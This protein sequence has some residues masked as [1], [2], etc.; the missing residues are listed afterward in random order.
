ME[1][2]YIFIL[3]AAVYA[4]LLA[5]AVIKTGDKRKVLSSTAEDKSFIQE[6]IE[7]KELEIKRSRTELT[8]QQYMLLLTIAPVFLATIFF[9][10]MPSIPVLSIAGA[11]AG[12]YIPELWLK[13]MK[14]KEEEGYSSKFSKALNQMS[15]SLT[16]KMSFEKSI[17][18]VTQSELIDGNVKTDFKQLLADINVGVPVV[19]AFERYAEFTENEDVRDTATAISIMLE[20]GKGEGEGI[21]KIQKNIEDRMLYRKQRK[22]MMTESKILVYTS[23]FIPLLVFLIIGTTSSETMSYYFS[24]MKMTVLFFGIIVWVLIGSVVIHKLMGNTKDI[25]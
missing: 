5:V 17:E 7:K 22:A 16:S 12:F 19:K 21:K 3:V 18:A 11:V 9:I 8:I 13:Y 10:F 24:D 15:A 23:D 2:T 4:S 1:F 20:L 14:S 25:S 6:F